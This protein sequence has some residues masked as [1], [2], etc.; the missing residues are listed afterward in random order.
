[1]ILFKPYHVPLILEGKKTE[2][3]RLWKYPRIRVGRTYQAKTT[4]YGQP[5]ALIEITALWREKLGDI[6]PE[7]V[8]AEGYDSFE[9]F[10]KAWIDINGIWNPDDEVWAVR[11]KVVRKFKASSA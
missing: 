3:R 6:T 10:M 2:T 7:S 11:F 8:R 9:E 4:L 1:L 5:F